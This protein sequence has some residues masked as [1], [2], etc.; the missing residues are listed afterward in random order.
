ME[1]LQRQSILK[2]IF[3]VENNLLFEDLMDIL[4]SL[5]IA[6]SEQNKELVLSLLKKLVPEWKS[7]CN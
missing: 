1:N 3:A 2:F 7:N 6:V 4:K 5:K